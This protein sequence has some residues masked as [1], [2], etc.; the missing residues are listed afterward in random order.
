MTPALKSGVSCFAQSD[1]TQIRRG[2]S[3]FF[4][5]DARLTPHIANIL[6]QLDGTRSV[7]SI[8]AAMPPQFGRLLGACLQ[9]LT[10]SRMLTSGTLAEAQSAFPGLA[11]V[12]RIR[13][14][15]ADW[16]GCAQEWSTSR[17]G[18]G[19]PDASVAIV[20][21]LT[22]SGVG[23]VASLSASE[24][25]HADVDFR[26]W[27]ATDCAQFDT[28]ILACC[29][30]FPG[31]FV[32]ALEVAGRCAILRNCVPLSSDLQRLQTRLQAEPAL[33]SLAAQLVRDAHIAYELLLVCAERHGAAA[34]IQP[35]L[36]VIDANGTVQSHALLPFIGG[37]AG[38]VIA[39][40][41]R[42][43]VQA[44][45]RPSFCHDW[46]LPSGPLAIG[47]TSE[48]MRFPLAH[49]K[50]A[51]S[52]PAIAADGTAVTHVIDWGLDPAQAERKAIAAAII[53]HGASS[54]AT[55]GK[56]YCAYAVDEDVEAAR[57]TA[58]AEVY[59]QWLLAERR[60]LLTGAVT[61]DRNQLDPAAQI[62]LRLVSHL[63]GAAP[64]LRSFAHAGT[65]S[66]IVW[67]DSKN[68]CTVG[69]GA[70][71]SSAAS[72]SLGDLASAIQLD[73]L[74]WRQQTSTYQRLRTIAEAE[75]AGAW[76]E[77]GNSP[78]LSQE[79]LWQARAPHSANNR[80]ASYVLCWM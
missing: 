63:R 34:A 41:D 47:E 73:A 39:S 7:D 21:H 14:L 78:A 40:N 36:R 65:A 64:S 59:A 31:R 38:N 61:L 20:E 17:V 23:N 79:L 30:Q 10:S 45:V 44:A 24:L 46:F 12:G 68:M 6:K 18:I 71:L 60:G 50:I 74:T 11:H 54:Q 69:I 5:R 51:L 56:R 75:V 27:L 8:A 28:D 49:A 1:G 48:A 62:L 52:P 58:A 2:G 4:I 15:T 32:L 55:L 67:A 9:Q 25:C 33:P 19:A 66:V 37:R 77:S 3:S 26:I 57:R 22:R 43:L 53:A 13:D 35:E 70:D 72:Q 80:L 16:H 29:R 42:D 76:T